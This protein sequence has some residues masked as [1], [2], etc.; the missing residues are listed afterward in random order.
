M[1]I[2]EIADVI[3]AE[4]QGNSDLDIKGTAKIENASSS[5]ITFLSNPLYEK[6]Y[7]STNAG[8]I[9]VSGDFNSTARSDITLLKVKDPYSSFLKVL[10]IFS[11]RS[12]EDSL[13]GISAKADIE[14][15]SLLGLNVFIDSFTKI[16]F[17]SSVGND[18]KIFNNVSIGRNVSIGNNCKIYPNVTIYDS[19]IIKNNVII[20]SGTVIGSDGFGFARNEDKTFTKIVQNGNVLIEDDVEI[21]SNCC[22][23]RATMGSTIINKGVKIDNQVQIAHNV[24]IGEHT[25]ITAQVGISGSSKIGKRCMI[26]GQSGLVGHIT[27]A[28]D[29][30]IGAGTGVSKSIPEP[31]LYTGYRF[32]PVKEDLKE[33]ARIRNLSALEERIKNLEKLK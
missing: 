29:V 4:V 19:C 31:G 13:T 8:A 12:W 27:I 23:D 17:G 9:I 32:K 24:E 11:E 26:G 21:G 18:T 1:K 20:H 33:Q 28:D 16:D 14:D 10:N 7:N 2:S 30:N 15:Y 22:I 5:D 3:G 6:F 25:V